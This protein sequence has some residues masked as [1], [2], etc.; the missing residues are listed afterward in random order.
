[1]IASFG[2]SNTATTSTFALATLFLSLGTLVG[3]RWQDRAG[4]RVVA[5]TGVALWG[6]GN[7]LAG[8]GTPTWGMEWMYLTYGVLGG[9]GAGMGYITPVATVTRWFPDRRGLG[10]GMVV[11]DRAGRVL[12]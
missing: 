3:G 2:W 10:S 12:L 5:L 9:F 11:M 4:P 1:M 6:A 8:I 7:L